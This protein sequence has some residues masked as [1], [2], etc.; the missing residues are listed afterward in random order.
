[1]QC[2]SWKEML[3]TQLRIHL[4]FNYSLFICFSIW[5]MMISRSFLMLM[6]RELEFTKFCTFSLDSF[7]IPICNSR[8]CWNQGNSAERCWLWQNWVHGRLLKS[9]WDLRFYK[10]HTTS[11][12]N[13]T[14][15]SSYFFCKCDNTLHKCIPGKIIDCGWKS[16]NCTNFYPY[17]VCFSRVDKPHKHVSIPQNQ[18]CF[19]SWFSFRRR[20]FPKNH[21]IFRTFFFWILC[22]TWGNS[23]WLRLYWSI[24]HLDFS[25]NLAIVLFDHQSLKFPCMSNCLPRLSNAWTISWPNI[26]P[27]AA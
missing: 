17:R 8:L 15:D 24:K 7:W 2:E 21:G 19:R 4:F 13:R 10:R 18:Q 20:T 16:K 23:G 11:K 9:L 1:M 6:R 25:A 5:T 14:F 3:M 12:C 27:I 22:N 26:D